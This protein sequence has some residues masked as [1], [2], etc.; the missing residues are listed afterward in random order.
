MLIKNFNDEFFNVLCKK[1]KVRHIHDF[2]PSFI[3][4]GIMDDFLDNYANDE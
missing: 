2:L 3:G 1:N 4:N